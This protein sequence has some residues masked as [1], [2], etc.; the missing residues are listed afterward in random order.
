MKTGLFLTMILLLVGSQ[1]CKREPYPEVIVGSPKF[2]LSGTLNGEILNLEAGNNNL[3]LTSSLVQNEFGVYEFMSAFQET[4]C[5]DCGPVFS[6]TINDISPLDPE[7]SSAASIL[8][9]GILS[10]ATVNSNSD[11]LTINFDTPNTPNVN[12][13]WNFGD[14]D[15]SQDHNPQH[16][17]DSAGIYTVTL[18]VHSTGGPG[19]DV[20]MSQTIQVGSNQYLSAPFNLHD[21]MG[22]SIVLSYP[23]NLPPNLQPMNWVIDGN[24]YQGNNFQYNIPP[25]PEEVEICLNYYNTQADE[26]GQYCITYDDGPG[27][28]PCMTQLH[29]QWEPVNVN[30]NN[31]QLT[32][33]NSVGQHYQSVSTLN[34]NA[35]NKFEILQVDNYPA[36]IDGQQAKKIK[37]RFNAWLV[38]EENSMETIYMENMVAEFAFVY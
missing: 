36:G 13:S 25:G 5:S 31:V 27:N 7:E 16:T 28:N 4:T 38:N 20:T 12:F 33:R 19:C 2:S 29:Y 21:G 24:N 9:L 11:F 10:F 3:Y 26:Y 30:L 1:A 15:T 14:G 6:V 34:N 8:D 37:A 18:E 32:Y 17:Y 23:P 22:N 35:A